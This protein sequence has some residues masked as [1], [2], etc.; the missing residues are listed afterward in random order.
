MA[1]SWRVDGRGM[2]GGWGRRGIEVQA[3]GSLDLRPA[4]QPRS[5][6]RGAK[7]KVNTNGVNVMETI[8]D[9]LRAEAQDYQELAAMAYKRMQRNWLVLDDSD[10]TLT[11]QEQGEVRWLYYQGR[12]ALFELIGASIDL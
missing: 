9:R 10:W 2:A 1:G 4:D 11:I 8:Q 6:L 7:A 5:V 12:S 3:I